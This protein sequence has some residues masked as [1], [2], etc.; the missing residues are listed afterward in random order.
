MTI[1]HSL[2]SLS[3]RRPRCWWLER[4]PIYTWSIIKKNNL[5]RRK[6]IFCSPLLLWALKS[7]LSQTV[8]EFTMC[9]NPLR[10]YRI[11]RMKQWSLLKPCMD[12]NPKL[13][14]LSKLKRNHQWLKRLWKKERNPARYPFTGRS[15]VE[16]LQI[17]QLCRKDKWRQEILSI[18]RHNN[19]NFKNRCRWRSFKNSWFVFL[20]QTQLLLLLLTKKIMRISWFKI[21]SLISSKR[22]E[23]NQ[24]HHFLDSNVKI[25]N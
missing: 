22:W 14:K 17:I 9:R 1:I 10:N 4:I 24:R 25:S 8:P 3:H 2:R 6:I 15:L 20:A 21:S 11:K 5:R 13:R 12:S 19:K 18:I 23:T 7:S 16:V